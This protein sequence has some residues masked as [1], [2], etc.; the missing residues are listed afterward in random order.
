[1]QGWRER[2]PRYSFRVADKRGSSGGLTDG[3]LQGI[4]GL[5]WFG[6]FGMACE[7]ATYCR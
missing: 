4:A 1:M 3:W 2:D 5:L 7:I 6:S